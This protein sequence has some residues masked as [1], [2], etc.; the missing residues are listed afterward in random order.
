MAW[1]PKETDRLV[2]RAFIILTLP[3]SKIFGHHNFERTALQALHPAQ[4]IRNP[5][6]MRPL[7][8]KR[9]RATASFE[10]KAD[11]FV[12]AMCFCVSGLFRHLPLPS[13]ALVSRALPAGFVFTPG[14]SATPLR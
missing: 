7:S 3:F 12:F 9:F 2:T 6:P 8:L 13:S 1:D 4:S 10:P 5:F 11:S 14:A